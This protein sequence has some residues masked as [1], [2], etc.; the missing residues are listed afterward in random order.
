MP[1]SLPETEV[2]SWAPAGLGVG[3]WA[4]VA[5]GDARTGAKGRGCRGHTAG[6]RQGPVHPS[7]APGHSARPTRGPEAHGKHVINICE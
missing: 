4:P 7:P 1:V 3:G 5:T 6:G 2:P